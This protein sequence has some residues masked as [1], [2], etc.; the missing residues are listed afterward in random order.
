MGTIEGMKIPP[1]KRYAIYSSSPRH[2]PAS[3]ENP[4]GLC[5]NNK[6]E[7]ITPEKA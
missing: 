5:Y 2:L 3:I 7:I 1:Q 6:Q 4:Q